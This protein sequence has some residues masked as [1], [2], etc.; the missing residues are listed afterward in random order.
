[1]KKV[2][3]FVRDLIDDNPWLVAIIIV[4]TIVYLLRVSG[5]AD[6]DHRFVESFWAQKVF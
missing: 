3:E 2:K 5:V 6:W 1:M 4:C